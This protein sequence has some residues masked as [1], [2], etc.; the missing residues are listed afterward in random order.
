VLLVGHS[1]NRRALDHLLLGA[2][3][4]E[5]VAAPFVWREGWEYLLG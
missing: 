3:L 2:S 5:L 1:A 4:D